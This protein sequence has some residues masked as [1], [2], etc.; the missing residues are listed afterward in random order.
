MVLVIT[1]ASFTARTEGVRPLRGASRSI[2]A[3]RSTANRFRHVP[4]VRRVQPR[5]VAISSFR[6]PS[7]AASTLFALNT[8][9]VGVLRPRDHFVND[10]LSSTV[11]AMAF[12]TRMA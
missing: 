9:R 8:N 7:A 11:N 10:A 2:P 5:P 4:T 1:S 3:W 12:A 6:W